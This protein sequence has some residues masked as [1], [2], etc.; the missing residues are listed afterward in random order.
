[1]RTIGILQ[2]KEPEI[3]G[4]RKILHV[5]M[6]AF[7]AAIEQRDNVDMRGKPV[8]IARHPKQNAGKGVVAT[9]SYEARKYGIHSAMSAAE[10]YRLCPQ[11][12]FVPG[13][14]DY[15]R[16]ISQQVRAIFS[17]Y[18]DV[19]EP[20]S[21]DEAFLDVTDNKKAIPYATQV[22]QDI[23]LA[24]YRELN[25]TCSIG[26]SYNKFI[27]KLASD[28][29]KPFGLTVI[30]PKR[31]LAFL[32]QLPI[33]E[34]YGVG[35]RL[36]EKMHDL[37]IYKG[38]DLKALSQEDCIRYFGKAGLALYERVRGV[39]NR[40]V[41]TS[42]QPKSVSKERTLYP[43]V[44]H[45]DEVDQIIYQLSNQVA[46]SLA[47][48]NLKGRVLTLK[49]RYADFTTMTRQTQLREAISQGQDINFYARELWQSHG[50]VQAGVRLLGVGLSQLLTREY[51]H[52]K[53]PL[54]NLYGRGEG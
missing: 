6:D 45:E 39:D 16:Q 7:Y 47:K 33:D 1:M 11:A 35:S 8:V 19:I 13:R 25:L 22:A 53:L 36:A 43:F 38:A 10:A 34:F 12:I 31:A 27:A 15:Y 50:Q 24:I 46:D 5:D 2:F 49:M 29:K 3:D 4:S 18:T 30:T 54:D 41:K 44:Y 20:L 21:I 28:Y 37:D 23:Q 17:R 42:R 40:P 32:D 14:H 48:K 51:E 9:C 52:I 26:V